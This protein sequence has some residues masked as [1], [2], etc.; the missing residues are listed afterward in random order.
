MHPLSMEDRDPWARLSEQSFS[1]RHLNRTRQKDP[2]ASS[3]R[4]QHAAGWIQGAERRSSG[5]LL[6]C[7]GGNQTSLSDCPGPIY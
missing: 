6:E 4:D 5:E 1:S 3:T 7:G 2:Q